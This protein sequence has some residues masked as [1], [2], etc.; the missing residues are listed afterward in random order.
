MSFVIGCSATTIHNKSTSKLHCCTACC[1][2]NPQLIEQAEFGLKSV[3]FSAKKQASAAAY[4]PSDAV[5][6]VDGAVNNGGRS[7]W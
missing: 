4:E 6:H 7:L 3:H 2:T 1:A 5:H